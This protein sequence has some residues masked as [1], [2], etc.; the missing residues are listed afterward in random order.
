MTIKTLTKQVGRT[1]TKNS[2]TILTMMAVTGVVATTV[3]AVRATPK[4]LYILEEEQYKHIKDKIA[5][6][7]LNVKDYI[8]LTWK[9]YLP[10]LLMGSATISCI[11]GANSIHLQRTAAIQGIYSLTET[12]FK[13]YQAKVIQTFGDKKEEKVREEI[14]QD[15]LDANPASGAVIFATGN[16]ET[17]CYDN[18]SGRYF[19][20]DIE[21]L[22]RAENQLNHLL[23]SEMWVTLNELYSEIGLEGIE[24][25]EELGWDV[26]E[27]L[28]FIFT[29]KLTDTGEPCLVL[30][31][32][33]MPRAYSST[34]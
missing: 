14:I 30:T 7:K 33:S 10:A 11:L 8:R 1:M 13:E 27:L 9:E 4:V 23:F 3:L 16:G 32:R 6:H 34:K 26:D 2:P 25:G 22:R 20:S 17:L 12:A 21:K 31:H 15:R 19:K 28:E 29:S 18:L 24:L 5:P